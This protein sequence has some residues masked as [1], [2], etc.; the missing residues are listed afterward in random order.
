MIRILIVFLMFTTSAIAQEEVPALYDIQGVALN[1]RAGPGSSFPD[2]GDLDENKVR[3]EVISLNEDGRW[4]SIR[5]EGG[6][7]WVAMRF[8]RK[9]EPNIITGHAIEANFICTGTEPF[10]S[11]W[12]HKDG[13]VSFDDYYARHNEHRL[14]WSGTATNRSST[15]LGFIS[16]NVDGQLTGMVQQQSCSDG[17]SDLPFGY[18]VD[19]MLNDSNGPMMLTGCCALS[20]D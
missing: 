17:M 19:M 8:L 10:W 2:I 9:R 7:G 3:L 18:R 15:P 14:L 4:G 1:V 11:L 16:E 5:W 6:Q 13:A 20:L 12:F